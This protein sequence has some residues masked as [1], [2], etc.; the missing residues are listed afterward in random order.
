MTLYR[1]L[2]RYD[3]ERPFAPWFRRVIMNTSINYRKRRKPQRTL[4][5]TLPAPEE[6]DA[7]S[8]DEV[9]MVEASLKT[10]P[11]EYRLVVSMHYYQGLE[12]SDIARSMDVPVGTIKTWLFR[13]RQELRSRLGKRFG[14]RA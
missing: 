7:L 3:P 2:R 1:N 9:E 8:S 10:L 14:V 12:V 4:P 13:A 6:R 11:A 5:E